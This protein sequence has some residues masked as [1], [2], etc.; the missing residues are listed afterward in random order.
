LRLR[1]V[2]GGLVALC[3]G[4]IGEVAGIGGRAL[5]PPDGLDL[6]S[7]T[8]ALAHEALGRRSVIPEGRVLDPGVQFIETAK[9]D[10]PVKDAS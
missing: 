2:E 4:Q 5:Q 8:G 1:V 10:V 9:R 6:F 3:L 7:Q